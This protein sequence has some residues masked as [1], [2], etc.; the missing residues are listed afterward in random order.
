MY[1]E[2]D[3][4]LHRVNYPTNGETIVTY[5]RGELD[6]DWHYYYDE[7]TGRVT[8]IVGPVNTNW[9]ETRSFDSALNVTNV[10]VEDFGTGKKIQVALTYD[11][12]HNIT[13]EAIGYCSAPSS[14]WQ[15]AWNTNDSTLASIT[16]PEGHKSEFEYTNALV[17]RTKL[18]Y[19]ASDSYDTIFSYT[20]NGLLS[21]ATNAN[22]HWVKYY[23]NTYGY[24]TSV[25]PGLSGSGRENRK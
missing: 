4:Y 8:R 18:Y 17:S 19:S 13:S 10:T 21:G 11:D 3:Y 7:T 12:W 20:T 16:D 24:P 14:T 2:P 5:R 23:Y 22:G 15:Y 6:Q 9:V 25:V 1:L